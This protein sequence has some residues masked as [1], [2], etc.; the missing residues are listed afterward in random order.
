M[1]EEL[2]HLKT[3][4]KEK[5]NLISNPIFKDKVEEMKVAWKEQILFARGEGKAQILRYT[6][7]SKEEQGNTS[8][9]K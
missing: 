4:P 6:S 5:K 3:D 9:P 7:D 8:I 2:Y 1:Y